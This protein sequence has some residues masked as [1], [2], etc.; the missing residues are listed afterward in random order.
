MAVYCSKCGKKLGILSGKYKAKD[1]TVMCGSCIKED[2]KKREEDLKGRGEQKEQEAEESKRQEKLRE[3]AELREKEEQEEDLKIGNEKMVDY[4]SNC[5]KEL[6]SLSFKYTFVDGS[7][8]C[9]SCSKEYEKRQSELRR[10]EREKQEK[11][12]EIMN[13]YISK[14]LANQDQEYRDYILDVCNECINSG[15]LRGSEVLDVIEEYNPDPQFHEDLEKFYN[16]F[17]KKGIETNYLEILSIFVECIVDRAH[18]ER[19]EVLEELDKW[20]NPMAKGI[21][22]KLGKDITKENV[23]KEFMKKYSFLEIGEDETGSLWISALLEK[24]DLQYEVGEVEELIDKIKEEIELEDF[25]AN[26]GNPPQ[27]GIEIGDFT[28]LN[29]YEFEEYLKN[30]FEL[31]GYTAIQTS[32]SG[33]QGADLILSK[34]DEKI[35]VQAK[36]YDG[37][38]SNKAVQEI[39]AAKNYYDSDKAMVVTNSSFTTSAIE[40]AFRNDVELWDG[41]KLKGIVR[42]LE[43]KSKDGGLASYHFHEDLKFKREKEVQNVTIPCPCCEKEFDYEMDLHPYTTLT[44]KGT[45]CGAGIHELDINCPHCDFP[46]DISFEVP[47]KPLGWGCSFCGKEFETKAAAEEHEK[48]CEGK[49]E[50]K[51]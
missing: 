41:R 21:S 18:K 47:L 36:K 35:V 49:E 2:Y 6:G 44:E 27:K 51:G 38:V 23:T 50:K 1:G 45:Y 4:C 46:I 11:N 10:Q 17:K 12:R 19:H 9:D 8:L 25:E 34:D 5:G 20:L 31:I 42:D 30:L 13:E 39:A 26:L 43:D 40:L 7:V 15:I 24:F 22:I 37:K 29:G 3:R 16:L 14:Y 28:E 32:L 48:T 33:D